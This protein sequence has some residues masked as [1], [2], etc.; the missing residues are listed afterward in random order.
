[1]V[2]RTMMKRTIKKPPGDGPFPVV[3]FNHGSVAG[4]PR[5]ERDRRRI[6]TPGALVRFFIMRGWMVAMPQRRGRG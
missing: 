5:N 6:H 3:V 2:N 1:M 4:E